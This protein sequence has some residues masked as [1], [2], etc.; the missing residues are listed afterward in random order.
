MRLTYLIFFFAFSI[1]ISASQNFGAD[2]L[3]S[4]FTRAAYRFDFEN[5]ESF[6][7]DLINRFPD[8][9]LGYHANALLNLWYFMGSRDEGNMKVFFKFSDISLTKFEKKLDE[10]ETPA[11]DYRLG[12]A[13]MFRATMYLFNSE[14]VKSFW[15]M[16]NGEK[17]FER[18]NEIDNHFYD[19]YAG[20]GVFSYGLSYAPASVK[21]ALSLFGIKAD[22]FA[23]IRYLKLA[24]RKAKFAKDEAA[25][26][27]SKIY[28]D[29]FYE[30]DSSNYFLNPLIKKYPG[31]IF[32][33]YQFAI[34]QIKGKNLDSALETLRMITSYKNKNFRQLRAYGF[35]LNG[36]I[37]FMRNKFEKAIKNYDK[38]FEFART[39]D[40]LGY[41][42][43]KEGLA[44]LMQRDT[45]KAKESF[46]LAQNGSEENCK[47]KSAA[48]ESYG[49]LDSGMKSFD[50]NLIFGRNYIEAGKYAEAVSILMKSK[51][52]DGLELKKKLTLIGEALLELGKTG[53][54]GKRLKK[55]ILLET[56]NSFW[57]AKSYYQLAK[58]YYA[59]NNFEECKS[60]LKSAED[61]GTK[62]FEL[63]AKIRGL[64]KKV[65]NR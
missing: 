24:F 63:N 65:T 37:Y 16:K 25:F 11:L 40:F 50:K 42:S 21:T 12:E 30:P 20:L 46:F 9:P 3:Y 44:F 52:N 1:N 54:A 18:C 55:S 45:A 6:A 57:N 64:K 62:C 7:G 41:A 10:K 19:G 48:E 43:Y 8:S 56:E 35:F 59:L 23:G 2:S 27:L 29:Y 34:N 28:S 14:K 49:L 15:E 33:N 38:F 47:D 13:Y 32:F 5:A 39:D 22:A 53:A 58:Y 60:S 36:E 31:N 17:F 4:E 26:Q 61:E 51:P